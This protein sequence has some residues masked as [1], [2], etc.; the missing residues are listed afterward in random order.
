[1][2]AHVCY[3]YYYMQLNQTLHVALDLPRQMHAN[4]I[5]KNTATSIELFY[6]HFIMCS[7]SRPEHKLISDFFILMRLISHFSH[8]YLAV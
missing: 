3:E 4:M 6:A 5:N 1:M 2:L 7:I 8:R